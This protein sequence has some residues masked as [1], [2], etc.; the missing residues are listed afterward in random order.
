MK[1]QGGKVG[2]FD[3]RTVEG[4]VNKV[5]NRLA[6][7]NSNKTSAKLQ[8][9]VDSVADYIESANEVVESGVRLSTYVNAKRAGMTP[10]KAAQL[11][12]NITV[13][14]NKKGEW[15]ILMNSL[16][17]F[18][19]A[20]IQGS[21]RIIQALRHPTTRK[22]VGA[23]TAM[24]YG[25]AEMNKMINEDAYN[26]ISDFEKN[27]NLIFMMPNGNYIK[28]KLPWGYN[29][30]KVIGDSTSDMIHGDKSTPDAIKN[31]LL[32]VHDS[33]NPLA[34]GS[35][36]QAV[37]PTIS[38]PF[39]QVGENKNW[40]G[41]PIKP[42]QNPFG[43]AKPESQLYFNSSRGTSQETAKWLN[44]VT[45]G[46]KVEKGIVDV[47]P[48]V[49][50]HWIDFLGGGVGKFI[51]NT[52]E[53]G[54]QLLKGKMPDYNN[55]P[56]VRKFISEPFAEIERVRA[57]EIVR[58]SATRKI[59]KKE[60]ATFKSDIKDALKKG[61]IDRDRAEKLVKDF[62]RNQA[63][64]EAGRVFE[65]LEKAQSKSKEEKAKLLKELTAD[66]SPKAK[67]ELK[68]MLKELMETK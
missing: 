33:F 57:Q 44:D 37:S 10:A 43:A 16:Y 56:I 24:S 30:F 62:Q 23:I 11:A 32:A 42:E 1:A 38:D 67:K 49:V 61:I 36:L 3:H 63:R 25:L 12:K 48:E 68:K 15:G 64:I 58:E 7:Y 59:R 45:G 14:F 20:G 22:M 29:V 66:L 52:F 2:W 19:N 5:R 18:S 9:G 26:K 34:S 54:S 65:K 8:R 28:I 47:S 4:K 60:V 13:N 31:M 21:T 35:F 51:A 39:V 6:R 17:L 50:D 40:F 41:G 46:T 55:M 27:T 53:S